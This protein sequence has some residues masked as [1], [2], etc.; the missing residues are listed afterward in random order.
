MKLE[1]KDIDKQN[2]F[3]VTWDLSDKCNY[4][5]SYCPSFLHD[6]K[7]GWP[8]FDTVIQFID[9][10]NELLPDKKICY[11]FSGGE[12]TFW[13]HF[14]ELAKHIKSKGNYFSLLS[15]G[16]RDIDYWKELNHYVDGVILS[17]HPEFATT[18]Q[19]INISNVLDCPVAVNLMLTP[20]NFNETLAIANN[21]YVNSKMAI[22][23]KLIHDKMGEITNE[24]YSYSDEQKDIIKY[25]EYFR[26][27]DTSKIHRGD[28]L[29]DGVNVNANDLILTGR[30]SFINWTCFAGVDQINVGLDGAIYRADCMFGGKLG[31]IKEFALPKEPIICGKKSCNCLSDI[32]IRKEI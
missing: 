23:P 25:W 20:D 6:G 27:L 9:K 30:N 3:L 32:Y 17:Y 2:W 29:L 10:L 24:L 1:Y 18:E 12:P 7:N 31:T 22:W 11:R 13:K 5:C 21:L 16:S 4:R 14:L 26:P 28:L 19:F 15:N 8:D